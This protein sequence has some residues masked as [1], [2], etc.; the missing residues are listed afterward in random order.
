MS[1]ITFDPDAA[2]RRPA[3]AAP[4]HSAFDAPAAADR[5]IERLALWLERSPA[6]IRRDLPGSMLEALCRLPSSRRLRRGQ[7]RVL[8]ADLR[9]LLGEIPR[10]DLR[11][12]RLAFL[13]EAAEHRSRL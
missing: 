8:L 1:R 3:S 13:L 6:A 4:T 5:R 7:D 2:Y 10:D 9:A 12:G 11:R